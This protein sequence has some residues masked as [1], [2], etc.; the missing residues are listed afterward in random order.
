MRILKFYREFCGPCKVLESNF[1]S[2][3]IK[4]IDIDAETNIDLVEEYNI[5]SVPTI[6]M[7]DKDEKE[8]KRHSGLL[9]INDLK[10]FCNI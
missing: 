8:I 1:K 4:T 9:S 6:I 5:Q 10:E 2:L 3:N 7:I